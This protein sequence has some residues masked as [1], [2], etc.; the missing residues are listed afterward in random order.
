MLAYTLSNL[1]LRGIIENALLPACCHCRIT[2]DLM[3]V[4]LIDPATNRAELLASGIKLAR[5]DTCRALSEL[6][7]KLKAELRDTSHL[8]R[9]AM[10]S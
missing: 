6:I 7:A 9:H 10:A 8:A 4:E 3:T 2:G 1:E 5:L